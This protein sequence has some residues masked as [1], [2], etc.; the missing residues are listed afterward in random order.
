MTLLEFG[1]RQ[2]CANLSTNARFFLHLCVTTYQPLGIDSGILV[3]AVSYTLFSLLKS[4]TASKCQYCQRGRSEP[5]QASQWY[6]QTLPDKISKECLKPL[7]SVVTRM[8]LRLAVLA[9]LPAATCP[10]HLYNLRYGN[11]LHQSLSGG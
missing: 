5:W 7:E 8:S 2:T 1:Q 4:P 6:R 9:A 10:Y 3:F 11:P